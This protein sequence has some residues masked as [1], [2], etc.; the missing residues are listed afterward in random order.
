MTP[1]VKTSSSSRV[2]GSLLLPLIAFL[3]GLLLHYSSAD[4][5]VPISKDMFIMESVEINMCIT[6]NSS[7]LFLQNCNPHNGTMLWKW[8]AGRRLFN[9]GSSKCMGLYLSIPEEPL[10]MVECDSPQHTLSWRCSD[11][12]LSGVDYYKLAAVDGKVVA[13]KQL[14]HKWRDYLSSTENVCDHYFQEIH[15]H[16]GNGMG[17]P[18][19]FPFKHNNTWYHEC[20]T[21]GRS[22]GMYWC[23]TT[24]VYDSDKKWGYCPSNDGACDVLWE[25][26]NLTHVCYQFNLRSALP[27]SDARASCLAQGG[28]LLS[29]M[30]V[31]EQKYISNRLYHTGVM[32]WIGLNQ[33]D[34]SVGWQWSDGTALA[35]I[36]WRT[37]FTS[38][39]FEEKHCGVY[40]A[41]GQ[42]TWNSFECDSRL[43]YA[44][45]KYLTPRQHE[46]FENW[47]YYPT[48]CELDWSPYNRHCYNLQT[49]EFSWFEA[50]AACITNGG[51]LMS[52]TSLAEIEF[53]LHFLAHENVSEAW[54]GLSTIDRDLVTFQWSDGSAVTFTSWQRH[55]PVSREDIKLCVSAQRAG[56]NW[57][58][59]L[60]STRLV[61]ICKKPELAETIMDVTV[62]QC[63]EAW[64]RH[65]AYCYG[66]NA[67]KLTF[68][69]A[70][71]DSFCPLATI[72]NRFEQAFINSLISNKIAVENLY[73]W[74][75]LED[76]NNTG[77]YTWLVN[78]TQ[79]R[80]VSFTNW[81]IQQPSHNGGCVAVGNRQHLGRWEVK[82]C[83]D[84]YAMSLCK[85]VLTVEE[86]EETTPHGENKDQV[87]PF[88]WDTEPSL[89]HCYKVFHHENLL[90]KRTWQEAEDMCQ[91]F[92]AHL[93][94]FSNLEEQTFIIELLNTMF[95]PGQK[96][97]FW[98]G[99]NK[100]NPSS[101]GSWEWTDGTPVV[102]SF[103]QDAQIHYDTMNCAAYRTDMKTVDMK[104]C[105]AKLEW[106]CKIPK[107]FPWFFHQ[108]N[109]YFFYYENADYD[110]FKF[111]CT[112]MQSEITSIHTEAEQAFIHSRIKKLSSET[113]KWWIGLEYDNPN[114]GFQRWEDGSS[115]NYTNWEKDPVGSSFSV[116]TKHCAYMA[117]DT[118]LWSY[119][120]CFALNSAICKTNVMFKMEHPKP[121]KDHE[122]QKQGICPPNWLYYESKCFFVHKRE[123]GREYDW[124]AASH[125]C[126]E[127]SGV[128]TGITNEIDQ[129]FIIMQLFG[130]K[131]SFWI[132]LRGYH[133]DMWENGA[134]ETYN[135]WS[136]IQF[137]HTNVNS[138]DTDKHDQLCPLIAADHD[139]HPTGVR[140][141]TNCTDEGYGFICEKEQD[142]SSNV[143]DESD[144]FPVSDIMEYGDKTYRVISGNMS[145]YDASKT[146]QQYGDNLVSIGDLYYHGFVTIIVHRMGYSHWIGYYRDNRGRDFEWEDGSRSR[147]VAWQD[148]DS[149]QSDGNCVYIDTNGYWRTEDCDTVLQGALCLTSA[150]NKPE[151]YGGVCPEEWIPFQNYCY[152]FSSVLNTTYFH[153]AEDFCK[154]QGSR[155]LTVL[156]E[157]EDLF[158]QDELQT[159]TS[160]QTIWLNK[161][162]SLNSST[163]TW[164][165]G[166]LANYSNWD[167]LDS[168]AAIGD[169]CVAMLLSRGKWSN[170]LCSDRRGFVCKKPKDKQL[171]EN[172]LNVARTSHAV[173]P[174]VVVTT[175]IL[176]ALIIFFGYLFKKNKS[177]TDLGIQTIQCTKFS[178][179]AA[180]VEEC[181]LI[182]QL[183]TEDS[184]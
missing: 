157:E 126:E 50:S 16:Q 29:I 3:Y 125:Y 21:A 161:I 135:N 15:T 41:V 48:K 17:K 46:T 140:Y 90:R 42:H 130:Q 49:E 141:L 6:M 143:I 45:K 79:L 23:A 182:T 122:V 106:I 1:A 80:D 171:S 77:E 149:P 73:F 24:M 101:E 147:F 172:N 39:S 18:C 120:D 183:E 83:K 114:D 25:K 63:D 144:M 115:V 112:W 64:E 178:I 148:A 8:G 109:N 54:I 162:I 159:F 91:D 67:R 181:I 173:I 94:S 30:N 131:N 32:L 165:D 134:S 95:T 12:L 119:S 163:V 96:R 139:I 84:F 168:A 108:G 71:S 127:H 31:A 78:N 93:I 36:N 105:D 10:A 152:S 33:L 133:Y 160:V 40:D 103:W 175:L 87:C 150:G 55:E 102:S 123:D 184:K 145:W 111:V 124:Y 100:R 179:E 68:Q 11:G 98:T 27:W 138:S 13:R 62:E 76:M 60:C 74:I 69:E 116:K 117:S 70:L 167:H 37:N 158:I 22:N 132:G 85:Q 156:D 5:M 118:G 57:K 61:S 110:S 72:T 51:E 28:D 121:H 14:L 89:Q 56:G 81:N 75:A 19:V 35:F 9:I 53:L 155:I 47:K 169:Y 177:L 137:A 129:A 86:E 180:D 59:G 92:G 151:D 4:P 142:I 99:F 82:D 20:T 52:V 174:L 88:T 146:C 26:N 38:H 136:I 58:A 113:K 34:G 7:G 154:Q 65:G 97:Q 153:A 176:S 104:Y 66:F 170:A 43:P 107:D 164:S 166:T 128:L 2:P 44:C